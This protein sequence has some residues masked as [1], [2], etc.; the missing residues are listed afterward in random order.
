MPERFESQA[1]SPETI[2][3]MKD[4]FGEARLTIRIIE[5]DAELTQKLLASAILDQVNAGVRER[6]KIVAAAVATLAVA[7]NVARQ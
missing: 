7:G 5:E 4:A 2:K 6:E 1:Y 3:L